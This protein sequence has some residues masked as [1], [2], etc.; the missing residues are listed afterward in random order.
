MDTL[1]R[2]VERKDSAWLLHYVSADP[3]ADN[4]RSDARFTQLLL[5]FNLEQAN[6]PKPTG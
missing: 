3:W 4:L 1:D 2:A 6:P 5:R